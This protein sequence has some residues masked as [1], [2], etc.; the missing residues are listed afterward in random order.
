METTRA[1]LRI[2]HQKMGRA[3]KQQAS[4]NQRS[5][6]R[7]RYQQPRHPHRQ[8][9]TPACSHHSPHPQAHRPHSPPAEYRNAAAAQGDGAYQNISVSERSVRPSEMKDEGGRCR[10]RQFIDSSAR[11][12]SIV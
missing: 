10:E 9:S 3:P 7:S 11:S 1:T 8:P 5:Q 2:Q 6:Q 12:Q 4:R